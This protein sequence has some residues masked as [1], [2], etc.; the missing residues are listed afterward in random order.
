[1]DNSRRG[2]DEAWVVAG[3]VD[4]GFP[5][6]T[7]NTPATT[8]SSTRTRKMIDV[9]SKFNHKAFYAGALREEELRASW[10]SNMKKSGFDLDSSILASVNSQDWMTERDLEAAA[11]DFQ[12]VKG[13]SGEFET[14]RPTGKAP[15]EHYGYFAR[16]PV[17]E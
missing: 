16:W 9:S 1:M 15:K 7:A 13:A 3:D 2:A 4:A 10:Y 14:P 12:S 8:L 5:T 17:S 6:R 11:T